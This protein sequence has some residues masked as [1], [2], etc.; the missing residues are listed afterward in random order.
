MRGV[1]AVPSLLVP[2][3]IRLVD[4]DEEGAPPVQFPVTLQLTL[5]PLPFHV[6]VA[7]RALGA[8]LTAATAAASA[9]I[10][11]RLNLPKFNTSISPTR[12]DMNRPR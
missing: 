7:A 1:A 4:D 2:A 9:E 3:K 10:L 8:K 11:R 12:L 6:E 5:L